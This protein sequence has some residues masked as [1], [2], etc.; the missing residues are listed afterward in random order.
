MHG[1]HPH[2]HQVMIDG[3][4]MVVPDTRGWLSLLRDPTIDGL[5]LAVPGLLWWNLAVVQY[6]PEVCIGLRRFGPP[7]NTWIHC[8]LLQ[9][10]DG[11]QR[12][13]LETLDCTICGWQ[14][15]TANPAVFDIYLGAPDPRAALKASA[16][17][18]VVA[19]PRCGSP[20]PRLPIWVEPWIEE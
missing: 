7:L 6:Y 5:P 13:H 4:L 9:T 19:C 20:F 1:D 15:I 17:Y 2:F 12:V 8:G 14:G 18:P 11:W 3:E 10:N 16:K